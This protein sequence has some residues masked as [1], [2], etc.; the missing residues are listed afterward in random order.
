MSPNP[1]LRSVLWGIT[2]SARLACTPISCRTGTCGH[3][4]IY[5]TG[6]GT[7]TLSPALGERSEVGRGPGRVRPLTP[8]DQARP[9]PQGPRRACWGQ[10]PRFVS[11]GDPPPVLKVQL[12]SLASAVPPQ[13]PKQDTMVLPPPLCSLAMMTLRIDFPSPDPTVFLSFFWEVRQVEVETPLSAPPPHT[14]TFLSPQ[15][16]LLTASPTQFAPP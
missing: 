9:L 13:L 4:S 11:T 1:T 7:L 12:P 3:Q 2:L 15:E 8:Q 16:Q 14:H 10:M 5:A 6:T